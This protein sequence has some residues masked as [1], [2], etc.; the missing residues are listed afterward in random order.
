[1]R[2]ILLAA[3]AFVAMTGTAMA[4][5]FPGPKIKNSAPYNSANVI[6]LS[7]TSCP[8]L[9]TSQKMATD[10]AGII[11]DVKGCMSM[12]LGIQSDI[13]MDFGS[14]SY[15]E[16]IVPSS[17]LGGANGQKISWPVCCALDAGDKKQF[18]CR[19]YIAPN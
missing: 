16:C 15:A 11:E 6:T 10:H 12:Y 4:D 3:C 19:M 9:Y 18:L 5:E 2:H 1:M 13:G 14:G 7:Q 17:Y 8:K